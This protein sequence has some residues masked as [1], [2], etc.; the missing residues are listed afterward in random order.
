M[1]PPF[2]ERA[3]AA[4]ARSISPVSRTLTALTSTR[5]A[6]AAAWMAPHWP[7]PWGLAGSRR[8]AARVTPGAISLS[9]SSN[10][11]LSTYSA[12][13]N[14]VALPPGRAHAIDET[15]ADRIGGLREHYRYGVSQ[16]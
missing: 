1:R 5:T 16:L 12:F 10:F 3:K 4:T 8:T 14:P 15:S 9:S 2:G 13:V 11:P 6:G 7:V